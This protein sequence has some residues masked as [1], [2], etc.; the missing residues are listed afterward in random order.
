MQLLSYLRWNVIVIDSQC[1]KLHMRIAICEQHL[2]RALTAVC[3][4]FCIICNLQHLQEVWDKNVIK[5][6]LIG[7][8]DLLLSSIPAPLYLAEQHG[9][10]C[11]YNICVIL[12]KDCMLPYSTQCTYKAYCTSKNVHCA[13]SQQRSTRA[14]KYTS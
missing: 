9:K 14:N 4:A 12:H 8:G 3:C 11:V 10:V 5:D 2:L 1:V 7:D 6:A 13:F